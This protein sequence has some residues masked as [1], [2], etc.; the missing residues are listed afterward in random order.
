M[1]VGA[2]WHHS[3]RQ[4]KVAVEAVLKNGFIGG[5]PV[6]EGDETDARFLDARGHWILLHAKGNAA[7]DSEGFVYRFNRDGELTSPRLSL[8]LANRRPRR[9]R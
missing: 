4:A 5:Y 2:D 3:D 8:G 9:W 6:L 1:V 7:H